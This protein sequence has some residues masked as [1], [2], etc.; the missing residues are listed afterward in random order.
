MTHATRITIAII[1]A[2]FV[3]AGVA[4]ATWAPNGTLVC[5]AANDQRGIAILAD[6][7]GGVFLVWQDG[8]PGLYQDDL[9]LQKLDALGTPAFAVNG[10][11]VCAAAYDSYGAR[12]IGDDQGGVIVAWE[13]RR[14]IGL[15]PAN[16]IYAQRMDSR[17]LPQWATDGVDL[18]QVSGDQGKPSLASDG[19]GGAIVLWE[20]GRLQACRTKDLYAQRINANGTLAWPMTGVAVCTAG[21]DQDS[22]R[23]VADGAG[24]VFAIWSDKRSEVRDL[25]A[26]RL[27]GAGSPLWAANGVPVCSAPDRQQEPAVSVLGG[28]VVAAWNDWRDGGWSIY[29]QDIAAS[30]V[31]QWTANGVTALGAPSNSPPALL[32]DGTSIFIAGSR[33]GDI[34]V[35][36]LSSSGAP[37]WGTDGVPL[38]SAP[39]T[40]RSPLIVADGAG[41]VIAAWVDFR[42]G[43]AD[44]YAGRLDGSGSPQ[45]PSDG[46]ALCTAT[47]AQDSPVLAGDGAGGAIVAWEDARSGAF[48]VYAQ[49]VT[50]G[51]I[52]APTAAVEPPT[53]DVVQLA[54]ARP[55]PATG[56]VSFTLAL[57]V[58]GRVTVDV[59]D[60]AGRHVASVLSAADLPAGTHLLGW[61][62]ISA[63]GHGVASGLYFV[64]LTGTAG[65]LWR[66]FSYVR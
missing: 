60:V 23:V 43:N 11:P 6:G 3:S 56:H 40:Q 10:V 24:G 27:N 65:T 48:D 41:G 51:G 46:V 66:Q 28:G 42:S 34:Y 37:Q 21:D 39:G 29:T 15:G 38:C 33:G 31:A 59:L 12:M 49:R 25:Y 53:I 58:A 63:D 57:P 1:V 50:S 9:Y 18:S 2:I 22:P 4:H 16:E 5:S 44:I 26:Q 20:D 19:A 55:N 47:G 62:G 52:V 17:G 30:G 45:W 8:R 36:K 32:V 64:R 13:D 54:P 61:D 7:S 14:S 35:Q